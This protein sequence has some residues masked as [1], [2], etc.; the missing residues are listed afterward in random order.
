MMQQF[1]ESYALS[2]SEEKWFGESEIAAHLKHVKFCTGHIKE[3]VDSKIC[4][5]KY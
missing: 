4:R 5:R 2:L 3:K 1:A